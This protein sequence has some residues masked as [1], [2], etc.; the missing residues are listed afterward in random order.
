MPFYNYII[1][2][3]MDIFYSTSSTVGGHLVC[4]H[5]LHLNIAALCILEHKAFCI[6]AGIFGLI[7]RSK[8]VRLAYIKMAVIHTFNNIG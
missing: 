7:L 5:F 6:Y 1:I 3:C 8:I 4:S 2:C